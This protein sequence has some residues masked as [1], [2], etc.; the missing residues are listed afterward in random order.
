MVGHPG[1]RRQPRTCALCL[2]PPARPRQLPACSICE[3]RSRR[4]RTKSD[5]SALRCSVAAGGAAAGAVAGL[6]GAVHLDAAQH[7]AASWRVFYSPDQMPQ[8]AAD[9]THAEGPPYVVDDPVWA[10]LSPVV[11][12]PSTA[13][14]HAVRVEQITLGDRG[15]YRDLRSQNTLNIVA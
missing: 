1:M 11:H 4:V 6:G 15:A 13:A 7:A 12:G 10:W 8:A 3:V 9:G 5:E 2:S 14:L